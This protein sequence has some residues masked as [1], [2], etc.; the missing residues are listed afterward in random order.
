V[1]ALQQACLDIQRGCLTPGLLSLL[2][3][4]ENFGKIWSAWGKMKLNIQTEE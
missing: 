3:G 1:A 4:E 2:C